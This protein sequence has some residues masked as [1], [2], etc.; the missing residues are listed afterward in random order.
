MQLTV[1][2]YIFIFVHQN[3]VSKTNASMTWALIWTLIEIGKYKN[4]EL[5]KQFHLKCLRSED[6]S[7]GHLILCLLDFLSKSYLKWWC[8]HFFLFRIWMNR[9]SLKFAFF[10]LGNSN[11]GRLLWQGPLSIGSAIVHS[12]GLRSGCS[13]NRQGK[14]WFWSQSYRTLVLFVFRFSLVSLKLEHV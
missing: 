10:L 3:F 7:K 4:D 13:A 12:K 2:K 11:R 8:L 1:K 14:F 5:K 6:V 9:R